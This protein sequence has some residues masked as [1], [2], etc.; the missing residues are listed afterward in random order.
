MITRYAAMTIGIM[1]N[2][3]EVRKEIKKN[4]S[5]IKALINLLVT[6]NESN[7]DQ[8]IIEFTCAIIANL[9][10]EFTGKVA[11]ARVE[12]DK[13]R[14]PSSLVSLLPHT[15]PDII[16]NSCRALN[17]LAEDFENLA[18]I[19]SQ[20]AVEEYLLELLSSK[21]PAIQKCSLTLLQ[22][23]T[24]EH[25]SAVK[26]GDLHGVQSLIDILANEK[27]T[28]LHELCLQVLANC[29]QVTDL[30]SEA[31]NQGALLRLLQMSGRDTSKNSSEQFSG[32]CSPNF[33]S[34]EFSKRLNNGKE[35][36]EKIE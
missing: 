19:R 1:S 22:N 26:V 35:M 24:K 23:L 31:R 15:D 30:L 18:V 28:D 36:L 25:S 32:V 10:L 3:L 5:W 21:Y 8:V 17:N 33:S 9:S 6:R 13:S 16:F 11:L 27:L 20:E 4:D 14:L 29:F 2:E 12:D 34:E 7:L